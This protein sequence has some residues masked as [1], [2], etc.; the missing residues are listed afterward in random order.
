VTAE[1]PAAVSPWTIGWL[2][3]EDV[4]PLVALERASG[5]EEIW[6]VPQFHYLVASKHEGCLVARRQG[7]PLGYVAFRVD[8]L[9]PI[10]LSIV[11]GAPHRRQGLGRALLEALYVLPYFKKKGSAR[12]YV[13]ERSLDAQLFLKACGFRCDGIL[14]EVFDCPPEDAYRFRKPVPGP[15]EK[16][17]P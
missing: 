15:H 10:L 5:M 13:R 11:V 16:L 17:P 9:E 3:A 2:E 8:E 14:P 6:S 1:I 7:R 12:A 4:L